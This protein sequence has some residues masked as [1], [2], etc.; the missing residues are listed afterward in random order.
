MMPHCVLIIED[1][2]D[3]AARLKNAVAVHANLVVGDVCW[4]LDH[5]LQRL[6]DLKPRVVLVD[7][8]LPDGSGIE[9]IKAVAAA[10]W[11]VD[12]LVISIFGDE[13][14][15]VEAIQAGARGYILKGGDLG[16]VGDDIQTLIDGGSPI[17]P[18]IA[19]HVLNLLSDHAGIAT[20]H[21]EMLTGRETEILRAIAR[22]YKRREIG[23]QLGISGGTVGNHITQIYRKLKVSSNTEAVAQAAKN[24]MI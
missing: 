22:G 6:F 18:A 23:D 4:T 12:A 24:G 20:S 21:M 9:A 17:S 14:R 11:E 1:R 3:I 7:L 5:G 8:G 10:D 19:R 16:Q 2:P 13:A 15:V